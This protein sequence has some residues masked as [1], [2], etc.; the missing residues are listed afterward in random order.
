MDK[1]ALRLEVMAKLKRL[2]AD[3][4][5]EIEKRMTEQLIQSDVWQDAKTIGITIANGLEWDTQAIIETGWRQG[6]IMCVPKCE[7]SSKKLSFY[8]FYD[9]NQLEVV[10]YHLREPKPDE[11]ERVGKSELDLLVVPGVV[12][13]AR[14]FRI[15]FG[16]GYY[17]RFLQNHTFQTISLVHSLQM[18]DEIP[19]ESFDIPVDRL[20]SEKGIIVCSK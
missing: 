8:R 18:I 14:G 20:I 11:R 6:K 5:H 17:D 13:D 4:K 10:Y 16:G 15:G 7:P 2:T 19:E 9:Y 3:E 12:F 1:K